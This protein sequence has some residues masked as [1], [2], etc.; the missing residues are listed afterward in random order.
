MSAGSNDEE[1]YYRLRNSGGELCF[2]FGADEPGDLS[3]IVEMA[4]ECRS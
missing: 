4:T 3:P 2:Y 1:H